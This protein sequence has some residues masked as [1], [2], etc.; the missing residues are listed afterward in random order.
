MTKKVEPKKTGKKFPRT[1]VI[2]RQKERTREVL[3]LDEEA[4]KSVRG[5]TAAY[6]LPPGDGG[7]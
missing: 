5:G 1:E 2:E 4:L 6:G 3:E 7:I